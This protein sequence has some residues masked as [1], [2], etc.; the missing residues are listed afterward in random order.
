MMSDMKDYIIINIKSWIKLCGLSLVLL[1]GGCAGTT[2]SLVI[3]KTPPPA[4]IISP[5]PDVAVVL[6]GGGARGYAHIGVLME[7]QKAHIPIDLVVGTSAGSL[8]G[9]LYADQGSA[10]AMADIAMQAGFWDLA[11]IA[12]FPAMG[13]VVKGYH[14]EKFLMK[15]LQ[16]KT[17]SELSVPFV[18]VTTDL[19]TGETFPIASGPI[20]PAILASSAVPSVVKPVRLY[21]RVLVD[22]GVADNV[23]VDIARTYHPKIIIAVDIGTKLSD[24][25]PHSAF[26]IAARSYEI[27]SDRLTH[28]QLADTDFVIH[29]DV[30]QVG[31]FDLSHSLDLVHAGQQAAYDMIPAIKQALKENG[32]ALSP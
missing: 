24:D 28:M 18:A 7:L 3:P 9:V 27:T 16:A 1:L 14:L 15:N 22:G 32:I 19:T 6:G 17:F 5:H 23:P 10:Q 13:G 12:A 11:D 30:G 20:P 25:M 26:G 4:H 29:P 2:P 31:M 8:M 21:G